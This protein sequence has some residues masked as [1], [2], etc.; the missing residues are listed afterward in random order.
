VSTRPA[1]AREAPGAAVRGKLRF[2][3]HGG[4]CYAGTRHG[5][6]GR[7]DRTYWIRPDGWEVSWDGNLACPTTTTGWT[8]P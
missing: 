6:D 5:P 3:R 4:S 7:L 2:R 1:Q 8:P